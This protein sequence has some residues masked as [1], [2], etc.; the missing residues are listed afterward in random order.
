[1]MR[2]LLAGMSS[3]ARTWLRV[4]LFGEW[5]IAMKTRSCVFGCAVAFVALF[6]C[7]A[8]VQADI[9][10]D[11]TALSNGDLVGQ[12]GWSAIN[13]W[14]TLT[15]TNGTGAANSKGPS[16]FKAFS[17]GSCSS[18][19]TLV[20][21]ARLYNLAATDNVVGLVDANGTAANWLP[22][23]GAS[24]SG[25]L[26]AYIRENG[27]GCPEHY[28]DV[29]TA[30]DTYDFQLTASFASAGGLGSLAYKDITAGATGFT[31]DSS[32]VNVP[33][34]L[35]PNGLGKYDFSG[36]ALR[37]VGNGAGISQLSLSTTVTPEPSV[38][39]L[40]STGLLSL[41]AY[42]WRRRR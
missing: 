35:T 16:A 19:T 7:A 18:A 37:L 29:L 32:L 15:V 40:L 30:G 6:A 22:G 26:K 10:Y 25:G 41:L 23:F 24:T 33:L 9:T 5:R 28:G 13:G 17:I 27:P 3:A 8:V 2:D 31:T 11:F 1:M 42:A 36:V 21:T 14:G 39:A 34:G 20:A 38:L 4:A 12:D